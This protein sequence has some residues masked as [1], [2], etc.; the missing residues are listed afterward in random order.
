MLYRVTN[1]I[2]ASLMYLN[3][4]GIWAPVHPGMTGGSLL[5]TIVSVDNDS[6]ALRLGEWMPGRHIYLT[7]GLPVLIDDKFVTEVLQ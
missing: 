2:Q 3:S 1:M 5:R 7:D 6:V 4:R